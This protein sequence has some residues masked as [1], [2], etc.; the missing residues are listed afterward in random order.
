MKK[1]TEGFTT[2]ELL[3]SVAVMGIMAAVAIPNFTQW[4]PKARVNGAARQLYTELQLAKMRAVSENNNYVVV[5]DKNNNSYS[6]YDDQDNDGPDN[7]ELVKTVHIGQTYS[8]IGFGYVAGNDP[9]GSPIADE[10][11][12][13]GS[14]PAVT[15]VPTGLAD[16][17]GTV[18]LMPSGD[19]S[20][21]RQRAVSVLV[22][23]RVK[24]HSKTGANW[25]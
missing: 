2:V 6:I 25:N 16:K 3:V 7:D 15:F 22:T 11:G 18:Y 14:P 23:G 9:Y 12:F 8:G 24:V 21:D 4:L 13:S 17:S 1:G 5:F 20:G 10:V 19:T